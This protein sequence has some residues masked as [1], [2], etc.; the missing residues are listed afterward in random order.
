M[1]HHFN[2]NIFILI[3]D[4]LKNI[5]L[6]KLKL[7]LHNK[8]EIIDSI[9]RGIDKNKTIMS[10][11]FN[12]LRYYLYF[13]NCFVPLKLIC[14]I[15]LIEFRKSFMG[16]THYIDGIIESDLSNPI[17]VGRDTYK[18]PFLTLKYKCRDSTYF[19]LHKTIKT[20][21][22]NIAVL[23]I[24]QRYTDINESFQDKSNTTWCKAGSIYGDY[25]ILN[26]TSCLL[27]KHD[28][29]SV[30]INLIKLMTNEKPY[31]DQFF[32]NLQSINERRKRIEIDCY[33]PISIK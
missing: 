20:D 7:I 3:I 19:Q 17:M 4:Y 21:T 18:R 14:K 24:F 2:N 15:P 32:D 8:P 29:I 13:K 27:N 31:Y 5:D 16:Q 6:N 12:L 23:T 22:N 1:I 11:R 28:K 30:I 26:S 9:D 10:K 33:L 25:P